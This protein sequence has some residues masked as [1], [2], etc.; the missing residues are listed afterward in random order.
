[1]CGRF[2]LTSPP[3]AVRAVFG[4]E[5]RP[6]FPPRHNIAPT[7]PIAVVRVD[8]GR[9]SFVLMRWGLIPS[10]VKDPRA[11]SVLINARAETIADKPAFR[12]A[13]RRRRALVPADGWY[14]WQA[15]GKGPKQPFL[16][17]PTRGGPIALAALW[18]TWVG[19]D[20]SEID[21]AAL[22]TTDASPA[23]SGVHDRMPAIIGDARDR[24]LWLDAATEPDAAHALL[25]PAPD[26][27]FEAVAV[28]TRVNAVAN[29][30]AGLIAPIPA[31][32]PAPA[33]P[34]AP[35]QMD[36]F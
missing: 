29:D 32:Q 4:Y 20:G 25:R 18:E 27:A 6:N 1:M 21:T 36:L 19:A 31:A 30:D 13:F 12:A 10:W 35:K 11:F 9:P 22:V 34:V 5:E 8:G 15:R 26:D 24:A 17:R 28:S 2:L 14:E 23:L 16:I 33:P 3:E 7:Q